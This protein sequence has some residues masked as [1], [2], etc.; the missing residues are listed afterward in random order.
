MLFDQLCDVD[1]NTNEDVNT[2]RKGAKIEER[3]QG[4]SQRESVGEYQ[5]LV[6]EPG[7]KMETAKHYMML[8]GMGQS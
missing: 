6:C 1:V 8:Q 7:G 5:A 3:V 2:N 4:A